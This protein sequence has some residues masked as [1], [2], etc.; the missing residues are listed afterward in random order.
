[1]ASSGTPSSHV[2]TYGS[3]HYLAAGK[4][5]RGQNVNYCPPPSTP[6]TACAHLLYACTPAA[7][8]RCGCLF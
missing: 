6:F 3:R 4:E 5:E 1:M 7:C 8:C 2:M